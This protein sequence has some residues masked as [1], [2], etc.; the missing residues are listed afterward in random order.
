MPFFCTCCIT[1][2]LYIRKFWNTFY[3]N[4]YF[5]LYFTSI[6]PLFTSFYLFLP[7]VTSTY[8]LGT[9]LASKKLEMVHKR[10]LEC[11]KR[12]S[13][14]VFLIPGSAITRGWDRGSNRGSAEGMKRVRT[15]YKRLK[16]VKKRSTEV[17]KKKDDLNNK[18]A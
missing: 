2:Y 11:H 18:L 12:V 16:E 14:R 15:G 4:L 10:F 6:L 1:S 17:Q 5:N 9:L 3:S 13:L 8:P 7:L